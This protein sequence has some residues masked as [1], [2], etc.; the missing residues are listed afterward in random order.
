MEMQQARH[1]GTRDALAGYAR[2]AAL[3]LFAPGHRPVSWGCAA[4]LP[5]PFVVKVLAK[6]VLDAGGEHTEGIFRWVVAWPRLHP[7]PAFW[8]GEESRMAQRLRLPR[9]R[10]VGC[11]GILTW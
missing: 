8:L 1:P 6:A 9:C 4:G 11:Q 10:G 7:G 2:D 5:I 3:R